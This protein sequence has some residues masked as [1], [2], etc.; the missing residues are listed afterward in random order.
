[1]EVIALQSGSNGNSYYV[2]AGNRQLMFDAGI[3]GSVAEQR[4]AQHG[5]DINK[6]EALFITHDHSDHSRCMGI[7]HRKFGHSVFVTERTYR[8]ACHSS[9]LG[10]ID[11]VQFFVAGDTISFGDVLVHSIPTPHDSEDGVVF[12]VEHDDKRVGILTDLGHVFPGLKDVLLSLDA[13]IIESN[14]DPE[15]LECGFYPERLKRRIRGPGGHISN[16]EAAHLLRDSM[17]FNRLRWACLCHL[18]E[19]NNCPNVAVD[20]HRRI[21]GAKLPIYVAHRDGASDVLEI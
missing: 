1:M 13:V 9:S 15:M 21:L 14:Y 10:H 2:S 19:E 5:R 8:A 4:L 6:V 18:S 7:F 20:T 12:V 17:F 3:S 11:N 16:N